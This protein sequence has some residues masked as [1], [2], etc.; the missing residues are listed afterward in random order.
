[1]AQI[2]PVVREHLRR[3]QQ[4]Q[5]HVYNRG[6]QLRTFNPGDQLLVPTSFTE[7][8]FLAKWQGPYDIIDQVAD[9]EDARPS[10]STTS[11]C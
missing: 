8:K 3:A 1:M 9:R 11:T 7:C 10:R 4:A 6:A 2:W 5:A